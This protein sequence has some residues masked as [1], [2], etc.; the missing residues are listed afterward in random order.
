MTEE[1]V[2]G[3]RSLQHL[4]GCVPELQQIIREAILCTTVDFAIIEGWRSQE[5]Q[6][7]LYEKNL[8]KLRWPHGK[9]NAVDAD[10][11]PASLAVDFIPYRAGH[12]VDWEDGLAFA[13]VAGVIMAV[14]KT[15]GYE[16]RWGG[17][18]DGDGSSTDQTFMDLGHVELVL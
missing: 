14:A 13:R 7:K 5:E 15:H 3:S 12:T 17:D 6:D 9:H 8:S 11:N 4:S 1:F 10:G 2:L 16:M 18:W